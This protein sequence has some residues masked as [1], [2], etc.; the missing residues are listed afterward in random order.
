MG[1]NSDWEFKCCDWETLHE[2]KR[3]YE[4][5]AKVRIISEFTKFS[6]KKLHLLSLFV[7][8]TRCV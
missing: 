2:R 4:N 7:P 8:L 3:C 5:D 6:F 1:I